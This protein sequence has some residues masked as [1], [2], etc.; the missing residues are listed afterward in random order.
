MRQTIP[1][2]HRCLRKCMRRSPVELRAWSDQKRRNQA[3]RLGV[4]TLTVITST[5]D[6][7]VISI[8]HDRSRA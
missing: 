8:E 6:D 1:P 2:G 5:A 3:N 4:N 7:Q